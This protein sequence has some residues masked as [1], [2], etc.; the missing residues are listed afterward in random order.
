[1]ADERQ[2]QLYHLQGNLVREQM[3]AH[4]NEIAA[5]QQELHALRLEMS[6]RV[7]GEEDHIRNLRELQ[8]QLQQDLSSAS[9]HRRNLQAHLDSSLSAVSD[10]AKASLRSLQRDVADRSEALE[11]ATRNFVAAED[12]IGKASQFLSELNLAMEDEKR[13]RARCLDS[14]EQDVRR[15]RVA[16]EDE[17]A[18]RAERDEQLMA[19]AHMLSA[20]LDAH[21]NTEVSLR[22]ALQDIGNQVCQEEK[23]RILASSNLEN[24]LQTS[25]A[26]WQQQMED[27][28]SRVAEEV[29]G[30]KDQFCH[31]AK[32]WAEEQAERSKAKSELVALEVSIEA[33]STKLRQETEQRCED[34]SVT[35]RQ[36]L[37]SFALTC[38][39]S[40]AELKSLIARNAAE[41][42]ERF[43]EQE[44]SNGAMQDAL[45]EL[46]AAEITRVSRETAN[47][48]ATVETALRADFDAWKEDHIKRFEILT[49][50][51][52]DRLTEFIQALEAREATDDNSAKIASLATEHGTRLSALEARDR[53]KA[54]ASE[55]ALD[56]LAERVSA[57]GIEHDSLLTRV[58]V[59]EAQDETMRESLHEERDSLVLC[60]EALEAKLSA[61]A[62]EHSDS[63]QKIDNAQQACMARLDE[64]Q[65]AVSNQVAQ[66]SAQEAGMNDMIVAACAQELAHVQQVLASES[67]RRAACQNALR[68]QILVERSTREEQ[69]DR[70][71]AYADQEKATREAEYAALQARLCL[72]ET[73]SVKIVSSRTAY[74]PDSLASVRHG[75]GADSERKIAQDVAGGSVLFPRG[76]SQH[77]LRSRSSSLRREVSPKPKQLSPSRTPSLSG[78]LSVP[79]GQ[80]PARALCGSPAIP[81]TKM[82][83]AVSTLPITVSTRPHSPTVGRASTPILCMVHG[84][85]DLLAESRSMIRPS[86][87][88]SSVLPQTASATSS[89]LISAEARGE[90]R[91]S[92]SATSLYSQAASA[93]LAHERG[94]PSPVQRA[95]CS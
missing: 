90:I 60:C 61:E 95:R 91:A 71:C 8:L 89:P 63:V 26:M 3:S 29:Q 80:S 43:C 14:V 92:A 45:K 23:S 19:E 51:Q 79:C 39:T 27:R 5:M 41:Y 78:S 75:T 88:A 38:E 54:V 84:K 66:L 94:R 18:K 87:S 12:R 69:Q 57:F 49:V 56:I 83:S 25:M 70:L 86:A 67:E 50:D 33:V 9:A 34:I 59:L 2:V 47:H 20:R 46:V 22:Q 85:S 31:V 72:L 37:E 65:Q 30:F 28:H 1:M 17:V 40:Q 16:Q 74:G 10:D 53:A 77:L 32:T 55:N 13:H 15:L 7:V 42:G 11:R 4:A 6:Q 62:T 68:D 44:A 82:P 93:P 21:T 35:C 76:G 48:K 24:T 52:R 81:A 64:L 58:C 73:G 36:Q